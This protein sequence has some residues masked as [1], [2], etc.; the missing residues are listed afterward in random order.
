MTLVREGGEIGKRTEAMKTTQWSRELGKQ[1]GQEGRRCSKFSQLSLRQCRDNKET[2]NK[3]SSSKLGWP[4]SMPGRGNS[5]AVTKQR[6]IETR[7]TETLIE[8][9]IEEQREGDS[10]LS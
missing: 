6:Q 9:K 8:R 10:C 4:A 5:G 7:Q 2:D 1:R 3:G